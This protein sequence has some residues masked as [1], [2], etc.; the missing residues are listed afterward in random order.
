MPKQQLHVRRQRLPLHA[1]LA[2]GCTVIRPPTT[3]YAVS[4]IAFG[5]AAM[6]T[7][8]RS[9]AAFAGILASFTGNRVLLF[10]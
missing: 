8:G 10:R 5:T 4:R 3:C 1:F 2:V 7:S 9:P 6:P